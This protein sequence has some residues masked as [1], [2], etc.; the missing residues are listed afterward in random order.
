[1]DKPADLE[2][3]MSKFSFTVS[4]THEYV[5]V[6]IWCKDLEKVEVEF[7]P[8]VAGGGGDWTSKPGGCGGGGGIRKEVED[9]Q[10]NQ[11]SLKRISTK[12][13]L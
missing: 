1:M 10:E 6:S 8:I 5:N 4:G 7:P 12:S 9:E 11:G 2:A 3:K 13:K